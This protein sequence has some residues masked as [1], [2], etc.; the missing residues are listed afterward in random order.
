MDALAVLVRL[1]RQAL[2]EERH[3]LSATDRAIAV[4][5][6]QLA[7]LRAAAERE[8]RAACGLADG[9]ARLVAYLRRLHGRIHRLETELRRLE[10]QRET[11][12]ARLAERHVELKRLELLVGRRAEQARIERMRHEQKATD[13]LVAARQGRRALPTR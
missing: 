2:D 1:A 4:L 5:C 3:A 8:R 10:H 9:S 12:A 7:E 13:E 11:V 6:G